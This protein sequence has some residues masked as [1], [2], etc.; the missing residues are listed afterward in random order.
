[1]LNKLKN[2]RLF[3][4]RKEFLCP[5]N[6]QANSADKVKCRDSKNKKLGDTLPN[7][8]EPIPEPID[9]NIAKFSHSAEKGTVTL[10]KVED[11]VIEPKEEIKQERSPLFPHKKSDVGL[12]SPESNDYDRV[13]Q[14]SADIQRSSSFNNR[15]FSPRRT[16]D[17]ADKSQEYKGRDLFNENYR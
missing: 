3:T 7:D 2:P 12:S 15:R 4:P 13:H 6:R 10:S 1:M 17:F 5:I 16:L 11:K 8:Q 14:V 9:Y